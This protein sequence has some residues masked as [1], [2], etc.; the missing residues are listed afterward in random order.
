MSIPWDLQRKAYK[1]K[2]RHDQKIREAIKAN[3]PD[4]IAREDI[5][6]SEGDKIVRVPLRGVEEPHFVFSDEGA[7]GIGHGDGEIGDVI[8]HRR[9]SDKGKGAG[10]DPGS[11]YYEVGIT[12]DE[13]A[14]LLF[15]ELRLPYL[16]KK[17]EV[18]TESEEVQWRD[19]RKKGVMANLDKRRTLLENLKRK[20]KSGER[21]LVGDL[22]ED[23]LRFK[24]WE[25]KRH[26]QS[27]AVIFMM[28]DLSGS[29]GDTET[30]LTRSMFFWA[31]RFLKTK[32]S[33]VKVVFITHHTEAQEVNEHDFF[34]LGSSGG[35]KCSS[36]YKLAIRYI[37]SEFPPTSWNVYAFH[38][39][40]GDNF[41]ED[42]KDALSSMEKLI[43]LA[44]M[45]AY[46]Q[47]GETSSSTTL[48]G[49]FE[50]FKQPNFVMVKIADGTDVAIALRSI[51]KEVKDGE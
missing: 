44:N 6:T 19:I 20:A 15:E 18:E 34:H 39:T 12:I 14:E 25:I 1:D 35:T 31:V 16:K 32:Y 30:Y 41:T 23:D 43:E 42:E 24:S 5:I 8:G 9:K 33:N 27:N 29:M 48:L 51:F 50:D 22:T 40:D 45:V 17:V 36:A 13:L 38:C 46:C 7:S 4:I 49:L 21:P 3:L 47:V 2:G 11:D 28:R 37:E 26:K 10:G